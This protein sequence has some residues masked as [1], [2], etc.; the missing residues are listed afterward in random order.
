MTRYFQISIYLL[1]FFALCAFL[2]WNIIA[3][4]KQPSD[5]AEY[6]RRLEITGINVLAPPG[7]ENSDDSFRIYA[8]HV[9]HTRPFKDPY[10]GHGIYLGSG[11]IITAAH[12]IGRWSALTNLRVLIAGQD[13]PAKVIK[14]G[15]LD[16]TDLAL[17]SV[18]EARLPISLRLRRNPSC[19]E[20]SIPGTNAAVIVPENII[21]SR[22]IS[23]ELIAPHYRAR[24]YSLVDD[25]GISGS[26]VFDAER[27]CLLGI[28]SRKVRK[29]AYRKMNGNV[30]M[31]ENGFAGYFV[32]VFDFIPLEFRF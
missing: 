7:A 21:R 6:G 4:S 32:P 2:A 19:K 31:Q 26:G 20:P 25:V 24:F 14:K 15:S 18:D 23:P 1:A 10:I 16:E 12:V 8:V 22:I 17:L 27:K 3:A 13:L 9:V 30:V 29:Y 5:A 11:K 28:M